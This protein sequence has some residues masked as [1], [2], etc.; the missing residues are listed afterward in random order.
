MQS[1]QKSFNIMWAPLMRIT[2]QRFIDHVPMVIEHALSRRLVMVLQESL[3]RAHREMQSEPKR[4]ED[5]LQGD[6]R[7]AVKRRKL[8]T[9]TSQLRAIKQRL[10]SFRQE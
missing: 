2:R 10:D 3:Q 5:M 8:K 4:M 6:H 9:Q 1:E 7:T